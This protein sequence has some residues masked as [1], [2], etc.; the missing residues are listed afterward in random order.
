MRDGGGGAAHILN[1]K[2]A[3]GASA[4]AGGFGQPLGLGV[5]AAQTDREH[6]AHIGVP[7]EREQQPHGILVVRAAGKADQLGLAVVRLPDD[8]LG[9]KMRALDCI[10][11]QYLVAD[12][13]RAVRAAIAQPSSVFQCHLHSLLIHRTCPAVRRSPHPDGTSA[14][15]PDCA[16]SAGAPSCPPGWARSRGR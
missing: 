1:E 2:P 12:A 7:D 16:C 3:C 8:L 13:D 15:R 14:R 4:L 9:N 5:F 11:D 6:R 10:H